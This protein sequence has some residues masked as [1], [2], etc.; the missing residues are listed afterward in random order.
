MYYIQQYFAGHFCKQERLLVFVAA[1]QT[2]NTAAIVG[3]V[4]SG[5]LI[6]TLI[7]AVTIIAVVALLR[8]RC[9][10]PAST[11]VQYVHIVQIQ[12]SAIIIISL[13]SSVQGAHQF[14]GCAN[15]HQ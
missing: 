6:F 13:C 14:T 15:Q 11:P 9:G 5:V 1:P 2:D 12:V 3:G 7:V 8:L 10:L 4:T